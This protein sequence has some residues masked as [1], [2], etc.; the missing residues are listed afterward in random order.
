MATYVN[1]LR[2]TELAT[3]EGSGT[4]GTTT[5]T[6]LELIGEAL[7]FG[8]QDCFA[9]NANATTTVADG[10]ADPARAIYFKV[11]SSAT[12][13][14]TR[15]LTIAPNT[16]SRM[17]FIENTTTGSQIITI[18]QGSGATVNIANGA[19]KAV[20]LDG[21]G[22]GAAVVDAFTDLDLTGTT[23]V[24]ALT[25][26]AGLKVKNAATSAGFVE[27]FE[28]SDNGTNKVTLIGPAATADVTVTLPAATD[29][30]VGKATT[31][32]LTNKTLTTPVLTTPIANAGIQLKNAAASAG[33]LEF[34]EDSDNGTNK[35]TLIGP[36]ATADVT[37][38]LPAAAD[39]LVGKATTDTLTNKTLTTPVV[40]AGLQLKN[41]ATSAGFIEFFEDSD[42]GANKVT[43]IALASTAD[44]TLTLPAAA[45]TLV[46]K[47][48]TDT[49]TNKTLTTPV[50]TTPIANAGIQLKNGS[51]GA[52][53][54]EFFED[55]DNGTNKVTLAGPASTA[56]ITLTLPSSA[57]SSGQALVTNGSGVLS[58]A[59][60]GGLYNDWAVKT[61]AY[62]MVSGD[63]IIVN[64]SG[65]TTITLPAS[66]AAGATV[67]IKATGGGLVTIGRNSQKINST[68][69]DGSLPSGNST[70][71]V[72]V[73]ATIGFLEL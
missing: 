55:S 70:Q 22:S 12:L 40:T 14:A 25:A 37:L 69:A 45:D 63:Q 13:N 54:L 8:T 61:S 67:T 72:F 53:F 2:L 17:M 29:T 43:L 28:D 47:A 60:V 19:V 18:K 3:G 1:D 6:N 38:T 31:D 41:A 48:T 4:W 23:T 73:D 52:G 68:A 34:F 9:S 11:T 44:V 71:L 15:T 64:A 39:T 27:F 62:T 33:F 20:Y 21:A 16:V 24:A 5:N 26:N 7:G 32:T 57:G 58:F 30:L 50:L 65:A 46:G 51:T 66:S 56:D 35:V 10:A 36:A 49:L 42:N 59:A